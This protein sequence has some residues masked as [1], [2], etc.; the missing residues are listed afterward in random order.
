MPS[1]SPGIPTCAPNVERRDEVEAFLRD[2]DLLLFLDTDLHGDQ[3]VA[4]VKPERL[5]P[6]LGD[7]GR[8]DDPIG[9]RGRTRRARSNS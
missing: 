9:H 7:G 2:S 3:G 8:P 6:R 1:A 4:R 5:G